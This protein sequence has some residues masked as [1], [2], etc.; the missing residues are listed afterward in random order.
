MAPPQ[1]P[2]RV[3]KAVVQ[4]RVLIVPIPIKVTLE[5]VVD[6]EQTLLFL[7]PCMACDLLASTDLLS[8]R[9]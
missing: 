1:I 2:V 5:I 8:L 3:A 7:P 4:S 9:F 6:L